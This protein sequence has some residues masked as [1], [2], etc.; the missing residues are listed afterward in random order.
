MFEN[1]IIHN[2][3]CLL[4]FHWELEFIAKE[5]HYPSREYTPIE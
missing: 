4:K 2:L 3:A 5:K 1:F